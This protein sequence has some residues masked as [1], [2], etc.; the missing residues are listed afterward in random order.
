MA[1]ARREWLLPASCSRKMAVIFLESRFSIT[2]PG[3]EGQGSGELL[4]TRF[5]GTSD[6]ETSP[7]H[8]PE[9]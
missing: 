9:S 4:K 6:P 8:G 3:S 1:D 7:W 2:S 5:T